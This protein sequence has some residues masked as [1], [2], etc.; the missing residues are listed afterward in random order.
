MY[1]IINKKR[2]N[3]IRQK[4]RGGKI[5]K[6]DFPAVAYNTNTD[7]GVLLPLIFLVSLIITYPSNFSHKAGASTLFF[8]VIPFSEQSL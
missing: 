4:L 7:K 2:A 6:M 5:T 1:K 3:E 8:V